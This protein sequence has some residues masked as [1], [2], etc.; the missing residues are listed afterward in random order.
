MKTCLFHV[1]LLALLISFPTVVRGQLSGP[2]EGGGI[3]GGSGQHLYPDLY[4]GDTYV[5]NNPTAAG[6]ALID[7]SDLEDYPTIV[8]NN[9]A[10]YL[11]SISFEEDDW[12]AFFPLGVNLTYIG[13]DTQESQILYEKFVYEPASSQ[14]LF[15]T[16]ANATLFGLLNPGST[17]F[18]R[19]Y[20]DGDKPVKKP[21]G[22]IYVIFT[23]T[24][25]NGVHDPGE[26]VYVGS[27]TTINTRFHDHPH[28]GMLP[29]FDP[30]GVIK[31]FPVFV[32]GQVTPNPGGGDDNDGDPNTGGGDDP[33]DTGEGDHTAG[34]NG[35]GV[36]PGGKTVREILEWYEE[37]ALNDIIDRELPEDPRP[38]IS[39]P[40]TEVPNVKN[41]KHIIKPV[42][43]VN[44]FPGVDPEI[45]PDGTTIGDEVPFPYKVK[46]AIT[47]EVG[48]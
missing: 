14:Y 2:G 3:G 40:V 42:R 20:Q 45:G 5:Q 23:D 41:E 37:K 33:T 47:G 21:I 6:Q 43:M 19:L 9:Y 16:P 35:G 44:V 31:V 17:A 39:I 15:E 32:D 13:F 26:N 4:P 12:D 24:N 22:H 8:F 10:D 29:P 36:V 25:G 46:P 48:Q 11:A 1:A 18:F 38:P 27:T 34:G 7:R 30:K 28:V